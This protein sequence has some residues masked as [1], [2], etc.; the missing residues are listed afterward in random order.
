[1]GSFMK[2]IMGED[3]GIICP[4]LALRDSVLCPL[5]WLGSINFP[6]VY[7]SPSHKGIPFLSFCVCGLTNEKMWS[8]TD[9]GLLHC[10]GA[11]CLCCCRVCCRGG[12]LCHSDCGGLWWGGQ[13]SCKVSMFHSPQS[14]G[15]PH[16]LSGS[17]LSSVSCSPSL[18]RSLT[19]L[20]YLTL[21]FSHPI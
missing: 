16:T 19:L 1:M 20:P 18:P 11:E 5:L 14:Q 7:N 12:A 4:S 8:P 10:Q 2:R 21:P 9:C 15:S 13:R 6:E 17:I 3:I